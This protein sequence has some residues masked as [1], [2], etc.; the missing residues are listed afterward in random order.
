MELRW[1]DR[2]G[3]EGPAVDGAT[4]VL[5]AA[6]QVDSPHQP[7]VRRH[8]VLSRL[9]YGWDEDPPELAVAV[10]DGRRIVGVLELSLPVRD[11]THLGYLDLV[12]DPSARRK[13]LGR[14]MFE[15][16]VD[17]S[18]ADGR[19]LVVAESFQHPHGLA[20]A[21]SVGLAPAL[22]SAQRRLDVW[23]LPRARVEDLWADAAD[24]SRD[25]ELLRLTDQIP[26][27]LMAG[28]VEM[29][30]AINDAP[31]DDLKFEDE[32]YSPERLAAFRRTHLASGRRVY[33]LVARHRATGALAGHTIV[34][35]E[36]EQPDFAHQ[37]DTSV[38]AAHRGHRLGMALKAGMLRWLADA[39]PQLRTLDTW[40]AV[41]NT[42]MVAVN[43]ALGFQVVASATA[44][45]AETSALT[46]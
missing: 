23:S 40:N 33:E 8:A 42:H 19:T 22:E 6:R 9:R 26:A 39:E 25:Y 12:V 5:E 44:F 11:N 29:T 10:Q 46:R 27:E 3:L 13:G 43:E 20:F 34:A 30:A 1:I 15:A 24:R 14:R 16:A 35:V 4:A 18:R 21:A 41:S 7:A 38:V 37:Y 17:R 32:V 28:M 31:L 2:D 45:Q 36:S